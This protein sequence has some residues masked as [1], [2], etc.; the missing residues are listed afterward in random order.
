MKKEVFL[1]GGLQVTLSGMLFTMLSLYIFDL[2]TKTAIVVG[3][4]MALS[5]T[6]IVLKI[7]N[8]NNQIHSGYGRITLGILLFQDLAVIP[9]LLMVSFFTSETESV[10]SLLLNTLGSAI[11]VF[12][13]LFMIGKYFLEKFVTAIEL[14]F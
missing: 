8:E 4:A 9:I 7:L 3:F 2:E 14:R 13:I 11:I 10:S 6:A 5:S 1:Y 12:F